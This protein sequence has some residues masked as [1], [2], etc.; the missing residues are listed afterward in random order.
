MKS[1]SFRAGG[2]PPSK[3]VRRLKNFTYT[4]NT[5]NQSLTLVFILF[6]IF[7]LIPFVLALFGINSIFGKLDLKG[8]EDDIREI[9]KNGPPMLRRCSALKTRFPN[10]FFRI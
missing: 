10:T 7:I 5:K 3:R 2:V 8:A 4:Y 6:N 9:E 1:S